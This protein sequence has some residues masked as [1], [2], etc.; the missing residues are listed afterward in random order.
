MYPLAKIEKKS[1]LISLFCVLGNLEPFIFNFQSAGPP[2]PKS[3]PRKNLKLNQW[4]ISDIELFLSEVF[5][6][7]RVYRAQDDVSLLLSSGARK[8]P[9]PHLHDP[10]KLNLL[11]KTI[12]IAVA[13]GN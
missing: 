11:S 9:R 13:T 4:N 2:P 3:P 6:V 8:L 7:F 1:T 12:E 5:R 10:N